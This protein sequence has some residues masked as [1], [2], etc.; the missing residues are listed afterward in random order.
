VVFRNGEGAL[1]SLPP[2]VGVLPEARLNL[3]IHHLQHGEIQD[4]FDLM[5]DVEPISTQ[6]FTLKAIA[7]AMYAE[8]K[9]S[10]EHQKLAQQY[11]QLVGSSPGECDTIAGRQSMVSCFFLLSQF[12]DVMIYLN[13]IKSY[14][15]NNDSFNLNYGQAKVALGQLEEAEEALRQVKSDRYMNDY[16]YL[17]HLA[18]CY[19]M[20]RK[21]HL[22]WEMYVH[23][24]ASVESFNLLHLI[25][26]DCY[27][28]EQYYYAAKAFDI[29]ERLDSSP[30]Y[31]EAKRG[32][33]VGTFKNIIE[34]REDR[35]LLRDI[36]TLLRNTNSSDAFQIVQTMYAWTRKNRVMV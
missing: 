5:K 36:I 31:W 32:A 35:E 6:E 1:Q 30:E 22:A 25:A 18:H 13:S 33:C 19:V 14:L 23:M 21:P 7:F 12:E 3:A 17:S 29:L 26:N 34:G 4:A 9:E 28:T 2:L 27:R 8:F 10:S 16:V 24:D 20:N 11:F 15:S